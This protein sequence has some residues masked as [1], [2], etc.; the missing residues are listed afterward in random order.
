[1]PDIATYNANEAQAVRGVRDPRVLRIF[2]SAVFEPSG[3]L[4]RV[5]VLPQIKALLSSLHSGRT[6]AFQEEIRGIDGAVLDELAAAMAVLVDM[7]LSLFPDDGV[8]LPV[9]ALLSEYL[10]ARKLKALPRHARIL[11]IGPGCG[12]LPLF[13]SGLPAVRCYNQIEVTQSLYILQSQVNRACYGP[14]AV[15]LAA[16]ATAAPDVFRRLDGRWAERA[17]PEVPMRGAVRCTH[18]PWWR[19]D[20]AFDVGYDVVMMNENLCEMPKAAAAYYAQNARRALA[21]DGFLLIAGI[22]ATAAPSILQERLQILGSLGFRVLVA[23]QSQR[24]GGPLAAPNLLLVGQGHPRF[25]EASEDFFALAFDEADPVVRAMYGL[26]RPA[27][28]ALEHADLV[29]EIRRRVVALR[30]P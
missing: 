28:S 5:E 27:G 7:Q 23:N 1:M 26:D 14:A 11:D 8:V 21:A 10:I 13:L 29:E 20:S 9:E 3:F 22:G 19:I 6:A 15:D 25:A 12:L 30:A 17:L 2:R 24:H 16:A 18:F 4:E